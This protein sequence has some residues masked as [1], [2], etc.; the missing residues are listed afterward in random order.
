MRQL[1]NAARAHTATQVSCTQR[2]VHVL[3]S[4]FHSPINRGLLGVG[5]YCATI[6]SPCHTATISV[7]AGKTRAENC[8]LF[9]TLA[10]SQH[11]APNRVCSLRPSNCESSG[12]ASSRPSS[13]NDHDSQLCLSRTSQQERAVSCCTKCLCSSS[14][15]SNQPPMLFSASHLPFRT[16]AYSNLPSSAGLCCLL[17]RPLVT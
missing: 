9:G 14:R 6:E 7:T 3:S 13:A 16:H 8:W 5:R 15:R 4:C 1:L 2:Y 17:P 11:E 10:S 12:P